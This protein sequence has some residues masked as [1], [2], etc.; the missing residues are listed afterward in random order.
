MKLSEILGWPEKAE[1][2]KGEAN[3]P[4]SYGVY[5]GHNAALTS[6]DREIDREA[7]AI[8]LFSEH[9][10]GKWEGHC[11]QEDYLERADHIISTMP[12]WLRKVSEK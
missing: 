7:L 9:H 10:N 1:K 12:T 6:C 2:P 4:Y 5:R 11:E 3:T 8:V